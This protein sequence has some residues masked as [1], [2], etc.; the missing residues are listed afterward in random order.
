MTIYTPMAT[1]TLTIGLEV[2][3]VGLPRQAGRKVLMARTTVRWIAMESMYSITRPPVVASRSRRKPD[4]Q[5]RASPLVSTVTS[6]AGVGKK[7]P[8]RRH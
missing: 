8:G 3:P 4:P 6:C 2:N 5:Q 1:T 7:G